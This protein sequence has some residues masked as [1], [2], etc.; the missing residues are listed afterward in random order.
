MQFECIEFLRGEYIKHFTLNRQILHPFIHL[1]F[2]D[3]SA[4]AHRHCHNAPCLCRGIGNGIQ[5][6]DRGHVAG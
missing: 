1:A 4:T 2:P 3:D 5:R 6:G